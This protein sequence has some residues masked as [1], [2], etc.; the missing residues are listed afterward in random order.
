MFME[1]SD[2]HIEIAS[3]IYEEMKK[4]PIGT[5]ISVSELGEKALDKHPEKNGFIPV[6]DDWWPVMDAL[7]KIMH[8]ER[9]LRMDFT[10][11]EL[12]YE[13]L[14]F[15]IPFVLLRWGQRIYANEA[16]IARRFAK[17]NELYGVRFLVYLYDK[18]VFSIISEPGIL[19]DPAYPPTY[20][21]VEEDMTVRFSTPEEAEEIFE[22]RHI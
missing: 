9:K 13:G 10:K 22:I 15:N 21:I 2:R 20:I 11:H 17:D 4:L 18:W 14:P 19:V 16:K 3:F 6:W 8:K 1:I 7:R 5:E 12:L